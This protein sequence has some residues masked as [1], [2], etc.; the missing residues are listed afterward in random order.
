VL[1]IRQGLEKSS[2]DPFLFADSRE[3]E[4]YLAAPRLAPQAGRPPT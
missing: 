2:D 3:A 4:E 1:H